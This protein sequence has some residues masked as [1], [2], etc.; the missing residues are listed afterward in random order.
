MNERTGCQ[1]PR[2]GE[3]RKAGNKCICNAWGGGGEGIKEQK[4]ID[5]KSPSSFS[6]FLDGT[7]DALPPLRS[8]SHTTEPY[9][10]GVRVRAPQTDTR[11]LAS[12]GNLELESDASKKKASQGQGKR[13]RERG[14]RQR[15]RWWKEERT[16]KR[17]VKGGG[18]AV[19]W[20]TMLAWRLKR[21]MLAGAAL[22]FRQIFV[23]FSS[24]V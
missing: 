3:G 9:G 13:E 16:I 6:S 23:R 10:T 18:G 1:A 20:G 7:I 22:I 5:Q 21:G 4:D 11:D 17:G 15:R 2:R 24:F 14:S 8:P 12:S 19:E